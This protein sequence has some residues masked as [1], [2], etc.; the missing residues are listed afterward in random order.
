VDIEAELGGASTA[1]RAFPP[2]VYVPCA[3]E[4]PGDTELSV[5]LRK[6][7]DGRMALLVY[8]ALDRLVDKAGPRQPWTVMLTRDLEDVR[9][10]TGFDL[11]FLDMDIPEEFRRTGEGGQ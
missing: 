1:A 8:S 2:L 11:V 7:R 5:D 6:T 3:P 9:L 4:Q 10:R